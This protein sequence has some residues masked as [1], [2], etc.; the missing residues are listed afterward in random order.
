MYQQG[1]ELLV[2]GMGTVVVFLT[3]LVF[4]TRAL[5]ATVLRWFPE[6]PSLVPV[7]DSREAEATPDPR[8]IAAIAA[9]LHRYRR[10]RR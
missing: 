10:E 3:A 5:S 8:H 1:L 7:A 2:Y 4:A 6:P 9:A